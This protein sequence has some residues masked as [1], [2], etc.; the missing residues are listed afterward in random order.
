MTEAAIARAGALTVY[1][2]FRSRVRRDGAALAIEAGGR[3]I[4]YAELDGRVRCLSDAL[5]RRGVGRGDR[6]AILSEN[7]PEYV[8]LELAAARLGAIVACQNWRLTGPELRH[9]LSLVGP[10]L[11]VVSARYRAAMEELAIPDL[12]VLV[13]EEGWDALPTAR[14]PTSIPRTAS[15]SSIP[16]AR[17]G[18]RRA[19][20]SA[21]GPR[22]PA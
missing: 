4:T 6:V 9:C 1:G 19:R 7:R 20:S 16:A 22:S 2:L 8:E 11:A 14:I 3:R 12:P 18:S 5:A 10:R 13:V 17:P 21:I 15:S